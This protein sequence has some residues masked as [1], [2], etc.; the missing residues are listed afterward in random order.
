[1]KRRV[2][3]LLNIKVSESKHVFDL[4]RI[5]FFIGIAHSFTTI[6]AF[7]YFIY[8]Y[9][10]IGLP[11]VYLAVAAS[12]LLTNL[13][14]EKLEH[15]HPPLQLLKFIIIL[16]IA[17]TFLF[18][19]GL[20]VTEGDA[21]IFVLLIWSVL[22]YM[23]TGYSYWGLVS[24]LFNIRESKRVFSIVGSG[25]IPAKLVG[26]LSTPLLVPLIGLSN[27]L[28]MSVLSLGIGLFFIN[29]LIKK[30]A[31]Q[32]LTKGLHHQPHHNEASHHSKKGIFRNSF[33]F[34]NNLI[35]TISLL[36]ILSYNVFNLIDYTFIYQVKL[37]YNNI[38]ALASFIAVFFAAGRLIAIVLKLIFSSRV[39]ERIGVIS[40]LT[41]TPIILMVFSIVFVSLNNSADYSLYIFGLMAL[42]TEVLRSTIQEPSFFILFQ[43]LNEQ[44]RLKGHIIAK[45]YMLPPSL[46]IVG[47]SIIILNEAGVELTIPYTI[48][49]LIINMILWFGIVYFIRREYIKTLHSS[50]VKG[51]QISED[52]Y[53]NDQK[54]IDILLQKVHSEKETENIYALKFLENSGY[55]NLD[56]LLRSLLRTDKTEVKR[57]ALARLEERNTI[58]LP[59]LREVLEVEKDNTLKEEII[60]ILCKRDPVFLKKL[61]N[62][63][64]EID[65]QIQKSVITHLLDQVEFDFLYK[66]GRR[67]NDLLQSDNPAERELALNIISELKN[68]KFTA[69]IDNLLNDEDANVRR[70]AIISACKMKN[71]K[72]LPRILRM[73]EDTSTKF[74]ALQGLL[75]YGDQLFKEIK[76]MPEA[77]KHKND[78]LKVASKVKGRYSTEYLLDSLN[79]STHSEKIIHILWT[80][81][82]ESERAEDIHL[83]KKHL[84]QYL[85][86][87]TEKIN[88]YSF[89]FSSDHKLLKSSIY[90]EI[91]GDLLTSLKISS[92]LYGKKGI[93]RV[94]ELVEKTDKNRIFNAMEMMEW[95]LPKPTA[96]QINAILD[97]LLDPTTITRSTT[98]GMSA[99]YNAVLN[100]KASAFNAWTRALCLYTCL[101]DN[102]PGAFEY[103]NNQQDNPAI[104]IM[105]E[106]KDHFSNTK[107][108]TYADH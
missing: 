27:L 40:S 39:I 98:T 6:C 95:V 69:A 28:L 33:F 5:Q 75:Y 107:N 50:I 84:H 1:M 55:P 53:I 23:I 92:I 26:Y 2:Y 105:T 94:I 82:F 72:L 43:P 85:N 59:L 25:D 14:Y 87:A 51:V 66:A 67:I 58:D 99:F 52:I 30:N 81:G 36:S 74:I 24:L 63:I 4:L 68:L 101:K 96:R 80:N 31:L 64:S 97:H 19:T 79:E 22:F 76:A 93:N 44:S 60:S 61:S 42:L 90:N 34:R 56:L 106:I 17:M 15:K 86:N 38:S 65:Y 73:L 100:Y 91:K 89:V 46:F 83:L 3:R 12:L 70:S 13:G 8:E 77:G 103:L 54:S 32:N 78:L 104:P 47:A 62:N 108:L 29:R 45:G 18:W 88:I 7:T 41:I 49:I 11:Y 57:Y 16:S 48:G 35:F 102:E 20:V 10:I 9:H 37:K 71:G 21:M